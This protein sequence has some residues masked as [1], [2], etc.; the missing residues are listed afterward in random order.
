MHRHRGHEQQG[1]LHPASLGDSHL[2]CS[3]QPRE[4]DQVV[5]RGGQRPE[6][7]HQ[8]PSLR[9]VRSYLVECGGY[10]CATGIFQRDECI[11][12]WDWIHVQIITPITPITH[13]NSSETRPMYFDKIA[14]LRK[15]LTSIL[16][17][18]KEDV[19]VK[20]YSPRKDP[21][22]HGTNGTVAEMEGYFDNNVGT[23]MLAVQYASAQRLRTGTKDE[24]TVRAVR[25]WWDKSA[26]FTHF[27]CSPNTTTVL[28][29]DATLGTELLC[30]KPGSETE[31][32]N[33]SAGDVCQ[34][35]L[36]PTLFP[37]DGMR[38]QLGVSFS[39]IAIRDGERDLEDVEQI[40]N[41]NFSLSLGGQVSI[42]SNESDLPMDFTARIGRS[43]DQFL[44]DQGYTCK[45]D[46]AGCDTFSRSCCSDNSCADYACN[47]KD[48]DDHGDLCWPDPQ[49]IASCC[50]TKEGS[51]NDNL[52][53]EPKSEKKPDLQWEYFE[54]GF[55]YGD[56]TWSSGRVEDV[57][58]AEFPPVTPFCQGQLRDALGYNDISK[59]GEK[60]FSWHRA[61]I[62]YFACGNSDANDSG[63]AKES[64]NTTLPFLPSVP[65]KEDEPGLYTDLEEP[66]HNAG[67]NVSEG[68]T[69]TTGAGPVPTGLF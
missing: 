61:V 2:C 57:Q 4:S 53:R 7:T 15:E 23:N 56:E 14:N 66:L 17:V 49:H 32:L 64:R 40:C 11:C 39:R 52:R 60:K 38:V 37:R 30:V 35:T 68:G 48:A 43:W 54:H 1:H 12:A 3:L 55:E 44:C 20:T 36:S 67:T 24:T 22:I 21:E 62:F 34:V 26:Y 59:F 33:S 46:D 13:G 63:G 47:C 51:L 8:E 58:E 10:S 28:P 45:C 69:W 19:K 6:G 5:I 42:P 41:H 16:K 65:L 27:W 25:M 29:S 50:R 31:P 18:K 9:R